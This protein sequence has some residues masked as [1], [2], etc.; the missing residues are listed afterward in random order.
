MDLFWG[1]ILNNHILA[2][3]L[4]FRTQKHV[5]AHKHGHVRSL[6]LIYVYIWVAN[7]PTNPRFRVNIYKKERKRYLKL[8]NSHLF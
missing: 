7:G 6:Y 4:F 3:Y 1:K 5:N 8:L 2:V